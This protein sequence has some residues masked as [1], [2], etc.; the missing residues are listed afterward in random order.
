MFEKKNFRNEKQTKVRNKKNKRMK[1]EEII[2][3]SD[4]KRRSKQTRSNNY[5]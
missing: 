2:L 5:H 1:N 4:E 3:S